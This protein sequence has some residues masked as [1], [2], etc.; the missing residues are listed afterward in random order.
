MR[1][2]VSLSIVLLTCNCLAQEPQSL[3]EETSQTGT[4]DD[5]LLFYPSKYPVGEWRPTNLDYRDIQFTADDLT[6]LHGWYCPVDSPRAVILFL[7]GNAGNVATRVNWIRYLQKHLRVTTFVFDYR[8][9]GKSDG[10]S[11]ADGAINDAIAA[12]KKLAELTS[13]PETQLVLMGESLGGAIA[14]ELAAAEPPKALILQSTF[15]SLRDVADN[16]Q[17]R[18][19]WLVPAN[20]LN[21]YKTIRNYHGPL[22]QSHGTADRTIPISLGRK[23]FESA[24]EPKQFV[25]LEKKDHND[26]LN[27]TY[28]SELD[29]FVER[30][31]SLTK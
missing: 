6:K 17:P 8:G 10:V 1:F 20:K 15:S 30:I 14:I 19:S 11:T 24:N 7:H 27:D 4:I 25:E 29:R 28:L 31:G 23:L 22:L 5:L 13:L 3:L 9:Y 26:W 12:R 18:L 16:L 21:S 2:L